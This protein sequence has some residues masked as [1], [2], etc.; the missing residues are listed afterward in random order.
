MENLTGSEKLYYSIGEVAEMLG[1]SRS[2]LRF[3]EKEFDVLRPKKNEKGNRRFTAE[4]IQ[5]LKMIRH[6]VKDKGYTLQGANEKIKLNRELDRKRI[7]VIDT[8][9]NLKSFL[10]EIKDRLD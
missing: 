7:N 9:K 10:T 6:L 8:L 3:W 2:Q 1:T 4:D 5:T